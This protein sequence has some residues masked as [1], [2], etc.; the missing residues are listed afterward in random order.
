M[1]PHVVA[2]KY[3]AGSRPKGCRILAIDLGDRRVGIAV[4]DELQITARALLVLPRSNWKKLVHDVA[5]LVQEFDARAVVVGLPLR[6]DGSEGA[7]ASKARSAAR[8]LEISLNVPV[9]MQDERLTSKVAEGAHYRSNSRTT[10][11]YA[12]GKAAALILSDFLARTDP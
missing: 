12:D 10:S 8:N 5:R 11:R 2:P 4:S 3:Q 9:F 7:E 6:L 1:E